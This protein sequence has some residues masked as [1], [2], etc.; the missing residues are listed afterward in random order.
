MIMKFE[1]IYQFFNNPPPSYL[2]RELAVCYIL[3]MILQQ[4]ESYG[5]ELIQQLTESFP[6]YRLSDTVLYGA[7]NFLEQS[8]I[9]Q[10][11]WKKRQGRGRPRKMYKVVLEQKAQAEDLAQLWRDYVNNRDSSSS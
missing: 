1:D 2:N 5:T 10:G 11:Y 6:Q 7:L 4:E 3:D 8:G 9:I